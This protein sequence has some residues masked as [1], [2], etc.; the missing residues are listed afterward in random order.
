MEDLSRY[1]ELVSERA[2]LSRFGSWKSAIEAAGLELSKRARRYSE[3]DYFEN[4]LAVWTHYRR[5]PFYSE[6]DLEPSSI[7]SG[8]YAG[9]FGTWARAKPSLSA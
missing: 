7:S 4:L 8:G 6:M 5:A 9:R 2:V 3:D 1:G